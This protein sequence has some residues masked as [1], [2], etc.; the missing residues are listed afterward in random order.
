MAG[1]VEFDDLVPDVMPTAFTAASPSPAPPS[2]APISPAAHGPAVPG[3]SP[4]FGSVL[5]RAAVRGLE[6]GVL[7]TKAGAEITGRAMT[8]EQAFRPDMLPEAPDDDITRLL[9]QKFSEGWNDPNWWAAH[10]AHG[11]AR[12]SPTLGL[13]LAGAAGGTAVAPGVGTVVGGLGGLA[14]G[15]VI[16]T[17]AP[18]YSQARQE[19]LGHD[20]AVDRALRDSGIAGVFS[21]AMG[22]APGASAFGRTAE[23]ALKKPISEALFQIFGA[24][25]ALGA[26]QQVAIEASHGRLPTLDDLATGYATN[27]GMG[28]SM[29][30][31][32]QGAAR[33]MPGRR[34]AATSPAVND[35]RVDPWFGDLVP[36]QPGPDGPALTVTGASDVTPSAAWGGGDLPTFS[37]RSSGNGPPPLPV[38]AFPSAEATAGERPPLP[39]DPRY[40][41]RRGKADAADAQAA[42]ANPPLTALDA[43]VAGVEVESAALPV[44]PGYLKT[45]RALNARRAERGQAVPRQ[46]DEPAGVR[47]AAAAEQAIVG[48]GWRSQSDLGAES[49]R[50]LSPDYSH[51]VVTPDGSMQMATRPE[52]VELASLTRAAGDLQPRDRNRAEYQ[53][54]AAE[55]AVRLDPL[56]LQPG[57]VSDSGSPIA[58]ADGTVLSG[59]GR[60]LSIAETYSNPALKAQADAYRASLGPAAEGMREPVL[61]LRA[62]EISRDQAVRFADLSNRTRIAEM[63]A[64]ERAQRDAKALGDVVDLYRGGDFDSMDNAAFLRAFVENV[65][66]PAERPSISANGQLSREGAE[67]MRGAVLAAAYDD[68]GILMRMLESTDDNIRNVTHAMTDVAPAMVALKGEVAAGRLPAD[69]DPTPQLVAAARLI[70]DLRN[71]KVTPAQYFQQIDAFG[72]HDPLLE[73]WVRAF[74]NENLN[75]A[76]SRGD[77]AAVMRA[78]ADEAMHHQTGGLFADPTTAADVIAAARRSAERSGDGG[79]TDLNPSIAALVEGVPTG[80]QGAAERAHDPGR[81]AAGENADRALGARTSDAGLGEFAAGP[82]I[83]AR[84]PRL[85]V[86]HNLSAENLLHADKLGELIMRSPANIRSVN[87]AFD[88]AHADSANLLAASRGGK[89]SSE[90]VEALGAPEMRGKGAAEAADAINRRFGSSLTA[91]D[92]EAK[93][94]ALG[95]GPQAPT[96]V[97]VEGL[98]AAGSALSRGQ[99]IAVPA[100]VAD[101][102]YAALEPHMAMV[103]EG[104]AVGTLVKMEPISGRRGVDTRATF[105]TATGDTFTVEGPRSTLLGI[106]ALRTLDGQIAFFRF[107]AAGDLGRTLGGEL[108][109]EVVHVLRSDDRIPQVVWSSLVAHAEALKL[110]DSD[111]RTYLQA[112]GNPDWRLMPAGV[113]GR[114]IYSDLYGTRPPPRKREAMAQ[115]AVAHMVEL[116]QHGGLLPQEVAPVRHL[117]DDILSGRMARG[118]SVGSVADAYSAVGGRP[119]DTD[120]LGYYSPTLEA[121]KALPQAKGTPEQMMQMLLKGGAKK[122]EIEAT[123]LDKWLAEKA[124]AARPEP[125]GES[126]GRSNGASSVLA[127]TD[128]SIYPDKWVD[129]HPYRRAD[130]AAAALRDAIPSYP[131]EVIRSGSAAGDSAYIR[132]PMGDIRIS[133]HGA[134]PKAGV[135]WQGPMKDMSPRAAVQMVSAA[136]Q[137]T[138]DKMLSDPPPTRQKWMSG[139]DW[140]EEKQRYANRW[141]L[142]MSREEWESFK[143]ASLGDTISNK[144]SIT[145]DEIVKYLEE[146][147]IG[148][149]EVKYRAVR[150]D[151][152]LNAEADRLVE[153]FLK[154]YPSMNP[155]HVGDMVDGWRWEGVER[156]NDDV[157]RARQSVYDLAPSHIQRMIDD[158]RGGQAD[159]KWSSYSL[160]PSNPTYRETV[161]HLPSVGDEA[162]R[163]IALGLGAGDAEVRQNFTSGHFPEPNITGHLMTSM[164]KHEGKPVYTIDQIQSDWGQK[165]RDGGVRDEA[166]IAEL[167]KQFQDAQ[168][169]L[170]VKAQA[171][172]AIYAEPT[173]TPETPSRLRSAKAEEDAAQREYSRI[174][175]ELATAEA[176]TTGHPL[177]NTTDQWTNT[178][179]RRAIRQAAEADADYIAIPHG[180]TVLSYNPGDDRGM[181]HFYG[182]K[183]NPERRAMWERELEAAKAAGDTQLVKSYEQNVRDESDME[184]I[185][186][187]NLRKL[188]GKLDR[189]TPPPLRVNTLETPSGQRGFNPDRNGDFDPERTGFTLFP[190]TDKA[191][192]TIMEGYPLF[193]SGGAIRGV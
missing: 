44:N 14:T 49:G 81:G 112:I 120:H 95:Y 38:E 158:L 182:S 10:I 56:Q 46:I 5:G 65:V 69:M 33:M 37:G 134:H 179:L 1:E 67:R 18:A 90:S 177:V 164:T 59:N 129:N 125:S 29:T 135:F 102:V 154:T 91:D 51:V 156:P 4:G 77:M 113:T 132:T 3:A 191:K 176:A 27:A 21:A 76:K 12:S 6:E 161:L 19:G 88:P 98:Q 94:S 169:L 63:S 141:P 106:R 11:A 163:N 144:S 121:A 8:G 100:R 48:A 71:K 174:R 143:A 127:K 184:G 89:W 140:S 111:Y 165:L 190:L 107:D 23:G 70:G 109:H 83:G 42:D 45:A 155:R 22:L 114:E 26:G 187:K 36:H 116:Y 152:Q 96:P 7:E 173:T 92:V 172:K 105:Q 31:A 20:A 52:V 61:V 117:L 57:R 79:V 2:P 68:P 118:E 53:R 75:R 171:R 35:A 148:L 47:P 175:A 104:V 192:R 119:R 133:D 93:R 136:M 145:R 17:L 130:E 97:E 41:K 64:T 124:K 180:D 84:S 168:D 131:F 123:G 138:V 126:Q 62:P 73:T 183:G 170:H 13:G 122:G 157:S 147:R 160:D 193:A 80:R 54:E 159:A 85:S 185:I 108:G 151:E 189:D 101:R 139:R 60:V 39:G 110:L 82:R 167:K 25:P 72:P 186:P 99:P 66:P 15:G 178:T 153:A 9:G 58:M 150:T 16:Q 86:M 24:Q 142:W 162:R 30:A 188:L 115:E 128:L 78:Y 146:N 87:A 166:K 74:Y 32:H 137:R 181:W 43:P 40:S 28:L 103:P 149:N 50:P 34:E 55:R